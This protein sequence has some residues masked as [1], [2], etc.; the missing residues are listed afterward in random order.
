MRRLIVTADDFGLDAPVNDAVE[1]AHRDGIL[2]C[3]SLMVS[4][5]A[6]ADAIARARRLP[7]LGVG[8][9]L[10]VV[11]GRPALPPADVPDLVDANGELPTNLVQAGFRFF[12]LPRVR[13]QLEQE[14]RA[15]FEAF[16]A[17]RLPLDH[18]TVHNHMHL[19]PTVL[20]LLLRIGPAYGMRAIRIPDERGGGL[21]LRPWIALL[22]ARARAAGLCFNDATLGLRDSGAMDSARVAR[23]LRNVPHGVTEMYFHPAT[24]RTPYI[25]R[26]L[27]GYRIED[28]FRALI[29]PDV[30]RAVEASG[31]RLIAFRDLYQEVPEKCSV[32]SSLR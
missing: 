23:L 8:L 10:T 19:H 2:T 24:A 6:A 30:R 26:E 4:A 31:A 13:R 5:P 12:F 9:H 16:R 3:A 1:R 21:A 20:G 7:S 29:D 18:V 11:R 32:S 17:T 27:P 22:R 28:E 14:I 15:Q 25:E